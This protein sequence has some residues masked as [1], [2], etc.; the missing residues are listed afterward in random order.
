MSLISSVRR[1]R[2]RQRVGAARSRSPTAACVARPCAPGGRRETPVDLTSAKETKGAPGPPTLETQLAEVD[3]GLGVVP[4][5]R[6]APWAGCPV[7]GLTGWWWR[8]HAPDTPRTGTAP[9]AGGE[10]AVVYRSRRRSTPADAFYLARATP[11]R[12]V[13]GMRITEATLTSY[14]RSVAWSRSDSPRQAC[15]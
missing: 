14:Y 13:R 6:A 1:G 10:S 12:A 5:T 2:P 11:T 15:G 8:A 3:A 4:S 7:R 9:A